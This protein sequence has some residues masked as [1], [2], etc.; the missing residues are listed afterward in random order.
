[1]SDSA[2]LDPFA[3]RLLASPSS[4]PSDGT[5]IEDARAG[6]LRDTP[7]V[8]G[9]PQPIGEVRDVDAAGVPARLYRPEGAHGGSLLFMHGGGWAI[10]SIDTHDA[11]CR[12][13]A[14]GSGASVLSVDYRLA[15]EYPYPA[16]LDDCDTAWYWLRIASDDLGLD[17]DRIA[18][19]GDSAGGA[20]AAG[21]ALRLRDRRERPARLQ[22]LLYPCVDPALD[23]AS[24][25]EFA[26]GFRLTRANMRWFWRA[27]LG[28]A[29]PMGES[30]PA[31]VENLAD[32]PPALV[33]TASHD[34]LRDEGEAYGARLR[35]AGVPT[36]IVRVDGT[37]HGFLRFGEWPAAQRTRALLCE[38]LRA[39][40]V[41]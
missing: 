34:L 41:P 12:E 11:L 39:A 7:A 14:N 33:I 28:G 30:A 5:D 29:E 9:S 10:G 38:R 3:E 18:L 16:A 23:S 31:L 15:P 36:E 25:M 19:A 26:R 40:L 17:F 37:L 27:Y 24:A 35:E 1:V 20:L 4:L 32:L 21:V 6:M 22:A 13:I 8:A 2:P